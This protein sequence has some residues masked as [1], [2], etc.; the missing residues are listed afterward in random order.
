ML[1]YAVVFSCL[2]EYGLAKCRF[3]TGGNDRAATRFSRL[4]FI[5]ISASVE[6]YYATGSRIVGAMGNLDKRA[7]IRYYG[8]G[9]Y[10][11]QIG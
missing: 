11:S 3:V 9:N 6:C 1:P 10:F 4:S 5:P 8:M 7:G 2:R